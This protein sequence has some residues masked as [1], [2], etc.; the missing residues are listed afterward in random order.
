MYKIHSNKL[1]LEKNISKNKVF[2][3]NSALVLFMPTYIKFLKFP[4]SEFISK[5]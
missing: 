3:W 4:K 5:L 2:N 1:V